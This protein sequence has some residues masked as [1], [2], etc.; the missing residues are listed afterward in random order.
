MFDKFQFTC[1]RYEKLWNFGFSSVWTSELVTC[2]TCHNA[3][4]YI[5]LSGWLCSIPFCENW[6]VPGSFMGLLKEGQNVFR[7]AE[8]LLGPNTSSF[9][10]ATSVLALWCQLW[11]LFIWQEPELLHWT[12]CSYW[13]FG[14]WYVCKV[15]IMVFPRIVLVVAVRNFCLCFGAIQFLWPVFSRNS[16]THNRF[17][18]WDVEWK[19][20]PYRWG[21]EMHVEIGLCKL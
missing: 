2:F 7:D 6:Y 1:Y 4:L 13:F 10:W 15:H 18:S 9:I 21:E 12:G 11:H 14:V 3:V 17:L 16:D 8:W 20:C 5:C 19:P